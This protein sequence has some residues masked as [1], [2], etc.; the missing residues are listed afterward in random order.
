[1]LLAFREVLVQTS[2]DI[3]ACIFSHECALGCIYLTVFHQVH[4]TSE[5]YQSVWGQVLCTK[6]I[7]TNVSEVS[8]LIMCPNVYL[9]LLVFIP[10]YAMIPYHVLVYWLI[11]NLVVLF[12]TAQFTAYEIYC[13]TK[14]TWAHTNMLT[15]SSVTSKTATGCGLGTKTFSEWSEDAWSQDAPG[16]NVKNFRCQNRLAQG[17][18]LRRNDVAETT[19]LWTCNTENVCLFLPAIDTHWLVVLWLIKWKEKKYFLKIKNI[20]C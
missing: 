19:A 14:H 6:V 13:F 11:D 5:R 8:T 10:I 3:L 20:N 7:K 9:H 1:M 2:E 17:V 12:I 15:C 4:T 16:Q 18:D